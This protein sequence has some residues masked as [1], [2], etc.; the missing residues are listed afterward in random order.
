MTNISRHP[1]SRAGLTLIEAVL[2]LLV[3][4]V[5]ATAA[6][7]AVSQA[8]RARAA[9]DE[10]SLGEGLARSLLSEIAALPYMESSSTTIGVDAGEAQATRTTL[11]D[12]DDYN[13]YSDQPCTNEDGTVIAGT[14][15]WR[16]SVVVSWVPASAST[17]TS[18]SDTGLKRVWVTVRH[19]DKV[20]ARVSALRGKTWDAMLASGGL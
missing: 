4:S 3:L 1:R 14:D 11:D 15:N 5:L 7:A 12:V 2:S 20:V 6:L 18:G 17:T 16:R 13:L 19:N 9:V 8:R 10:Q